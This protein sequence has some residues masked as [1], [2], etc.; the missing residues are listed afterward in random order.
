MVKGTDG[1]PISDAV[2]A[3]MDGHLTVTT[4]INGVYSLWRTQPGIYNINVH[5]PKSNQNI[6]EVIAITQDA[7]DI[8][9]KDFS[10]SKDS[11]KTQAKS[12]VISSSGM[13]DDR[14]N[15]VAVFS[16]VDSNRH[17]SVS[18]FVDGTELHKF[19]VPSAERLAAKIFSYYS[20]TDLNVGAHYYEV[21]A[22]DAKGKWQEALNGSFMVDRPSIIHF[23]AEAEPKTVAIG[24][25][26]HATLSA[27]LKDNKGRPLPGKTILFRTGFPGFFTPSNGEAVTDAKGEAKI[28]FT[29]NSGGNAVIT[30]R[31]P[32]GLSDSIPITCTSPS[33]GITFEF[34]RAGNNSFKVTCYV[35]NVTDNK[36][37]S[38]QTVKWRLKPS[39]ECAW[40]KGPDLKTNDRGEA[41]GV[42]SV[43]SSELKEVDVTVTHIPTGV[44]GSGSFITGGYDGIRFLPWKKLGKAT[45]WCEW[46]SNGYFAVRHENGSGLSIYRISDWAKVWSKKKTFGQISV[47]LLFI[48]RRKTGNRRF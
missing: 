18:L 44:S 28:T 21:K 45:E 29:P 30:A 32:S 13:P 47:V 8:I 16:G 4:D 46:S 36:P 17:A 25:N 9:I 23:A 42:F 31:S 22:A 15:F 11:I 2:V 26:N 5:N 39:N 19:A 10:F 38:H 40:T 24:E 35:K 34:H 14:Y 1:T 33:V 12:Q 43:G 41:R 20:L 7:P 27:S 37:A 3:T 48:G 6:S